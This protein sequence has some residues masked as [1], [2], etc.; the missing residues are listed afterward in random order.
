MEGGKK[1]VNYDVPQ[2]S[3]YFLFVYRS[4]KMYSWGSASNGELGQ[5]GVED[6]YISIPTFVKKPD[7]KV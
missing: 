7:I 5:G 3:T 4:V 2:V 6:A 1:I